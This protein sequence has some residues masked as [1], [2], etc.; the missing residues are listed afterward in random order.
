MHPAE[1]TAAEPG[2]TM[3]LVSHFHYDPVWWN[4]QA[5][6]TVTGTPCRRRGTAGLPA[7][8]FAPRF[9]PRPRASELARRDPDYKFVLAEVD[10]LKPYWDCYPQDRA[11]PAAAAADG[12]GRADG[13]HLQRAQH[14]P[15]R[16]RDDDP[17]RRATGSASSA[18]CSAATRRPPGSS[19]RSGTTRSSPGSWPTPG[20]PPASWARGPFHQW[21]PMLQVA[22]DGPRRRRPSCSSR[23]SSSGSRR[24]GRGCSPRYMPAPLQRRLVDGLRPDAGEAAGGRAA[25][26]ARLKPVAATRNMML[27]V[28][29]DYSPPNKWLTEIHRD[30]NAATCGRGS[31]ARIPRDFFAAVRAEL[32]AGVARARRPGT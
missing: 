6:Y 19:T 3:Y 25:S 28:G 17:Q 4:T 11:Y 30:W 16:R 32:A 23:A 2:W 9:R 29:T 18:T 7:R 13:R 27:P 1:F 31:C 14:Q 12:P 26:C 10:Y 5:A 20:S 21:G 15:D 8:T 22:G 24:A